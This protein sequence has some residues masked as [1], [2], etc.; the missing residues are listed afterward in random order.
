MKTPYHLFLSLLLLVF[1]GSFRLH[2]QSLSLDAAKKQLV[3]K[4]CVSKEETLKVI[5]TCGECV[6]KERLLKEFDEMGKIEL[7]FTSAGAFT[8]KSGNEITQKGTYTIETF[9]DTTRICPG[10]KSLG[11]VF[12]VTTYENQYP[13]QGIPLHFVMVDKNTAC[14]RDVGCPFAMVRTK[15]K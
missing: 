15:R 1:C 8:Q 7:R 6:R 14:M 3:S 4:W 2:A 5:D 9:L 13:E 12:L 11:T 10:M